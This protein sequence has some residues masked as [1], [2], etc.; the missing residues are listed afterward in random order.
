MNRLLDKGVL[1]LLCAIWY[2]EN[3][4]NTY[5]VVPVLLAVIVGA[6]L[7]LCGKENLRRLLFGFYLV[8]C[9]FVPPAVYFL[10]L[11]CYDIFFGGKRWLFLLAL[12]PL[13]AVC[14]L[15]DTSLFAWIILFGAV[16]YFMRRRTKAF[17]AL[18]AQATTMRDSA[19]EMEL[20]LVQKNHRLLEK[21]EYEIRLATLTERNR[22][23]RDIHDTVGHLLSSAI[24]QIGALL[25]VTRE[26][27]LQNNLQT[28]KKTLSRGM[29]SIR[30]DIHNLHDQSLDLRMEVERLTDAFRFCP[31]ELQYDVDNNP[32]NTVQIALL[33]VLKE[34]LSNIM[35]HSDATAVHILLREHPGFFQLIV[36]DNGHVPAGVQ[37]TGLGLQ[38]I[39][40]RVESLNGRVRFG[41]GNG[42]TVFVTIPKGDVI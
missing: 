9:L 21:Q 17:E 30:A 39:T 4:W 13:G 26:S 34:A 18:L 42:F 3:V 36:Q 28:L 6:A 32:A 40:E 19:K 10:P 25:A 12:I 20:D 31:A 35:K 7:S 41:G 23:A 37:Y 38:N 29:D 22:I 33:F 8:L 5:S 1:F 27:A 16:S 2:L 14:R 11:I 15:G 24:L